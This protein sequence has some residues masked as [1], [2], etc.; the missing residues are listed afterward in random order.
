MTP[1]MFLT[2]TLFA[3]SAI[4]GIWKYVYP[5]LGTISDG[6]RPG[7]VDKSSGRL[8]PEPESRPVHDPAVK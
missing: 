5:G 3:A 4:S 7:G 2:V 8:M 1:L 6:S